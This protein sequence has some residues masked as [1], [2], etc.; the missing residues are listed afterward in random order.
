M[1]G[2]RPLFFEYTCCFPAED[3]WKKLNSFIHDGYKQEELANAIKA[4][5]WVK[6]AA[7]GE[8]PGQRGEEDWFETV[9]LTEQNSPRYVRENL[10]RL[11]TG[12]IPANYRET[13]RQL[14]GV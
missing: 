13:R 7:R 6:A 5:H 8:Y 4:N 3:I 11:K 10:A 2:E 14:Y 12:I 9:E 1:A